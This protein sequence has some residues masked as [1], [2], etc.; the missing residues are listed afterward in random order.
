VPGSGHIAFAPRRD[1]RAEASADKRLTI[2]GGS[3]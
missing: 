3:A 2:G 1:G